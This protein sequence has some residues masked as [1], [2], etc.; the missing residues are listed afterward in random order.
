MIWLK[1]GIVAALL[2]AAGY[3]VHA[4]NSALERA[5]VAERSVADAKGALDD[6]NLAVDKL[7]ELAVM[8]NTLNI[9]A[10]KEAANERQRAAAMW[11]ALQD[12]R[13][14]PKVGAWLDAPV[15][16]AVRSVRRANAAVRPGGGVQRPDSTAKPDPGTGLQRRDERGAAVGD[17]GTGRVAFQPAGLQ[18]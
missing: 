7:R 11:A 5:A 13:K 2:A 1:L 4:Y 18:P 12:E 16:P 14:D 8:A 9:N 10:Q 3:A 15:P 17:R 6:A